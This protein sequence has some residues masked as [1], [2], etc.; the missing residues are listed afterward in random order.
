[1]FSA[2]KTMQFYKTSHWGASGGRHGAARGH[3][4]S[5]R[6]RRGMTGA[7]P[8]RGADRAGAVARPCACKRRSARR[9]ARH[10]VHARGARAW[11]RAAEPRGVRAREGREVAVAREPGGAR[12]QGK[13]EK[14]REEEGGEEKGKKG[15]E[16]KGK[17]RKEEE[18]RLGRKEKK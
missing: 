16:K 4:L 10:V 1:M 15:K 7:R 6:V 14:R 17:E 18:E 8:A 13:G 11:A 12:E 5:V 9:L 3:A 2:H